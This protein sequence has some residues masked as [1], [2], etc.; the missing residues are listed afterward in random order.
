MVVD[1]GSR[2]VQSKKELGQKVDVW[3]RSRSRLRC[4]V[5][6][7]SGLELALDLGCLRWTWALP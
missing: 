3:S 4:T 7:E 6:V 2:S 1:V 5:D